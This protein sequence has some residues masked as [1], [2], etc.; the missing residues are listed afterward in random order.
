MIAI[1]MS[2]LLLAAILLR[3]QDGEPTLT[4]DESTWLALGRAIVRNLL[5]AL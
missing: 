2:V 5:R 3:W 1:V 4:T